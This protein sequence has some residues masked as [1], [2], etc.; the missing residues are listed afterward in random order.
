[1]GS[2]IE[3]GKAHNFIGQGGNGGQNNTGIELIETKLTADGIISLSGTGGDGINIKRAVGIQ[4][5]DEV[6]ESSLKAPLRPF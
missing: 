4:I 3:G 2:T 1:M 5:G 6:V